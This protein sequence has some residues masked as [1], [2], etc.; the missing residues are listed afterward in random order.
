MKIKVIIKRPDEA[1]GHMT[2]IENSLKNLQ[3]TVDGYIETVTIGTDLVIICN[4]EG[5]LKGLP[6][7]CTICDMDFFGDLIFAGID[8][9][10]FADIPLSMKDFK[11]LMVQPPLPSR[12]ACFSTIRDLLVNEHEKS[13]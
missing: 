6:Y 12:I 1:V 11:A 10:E 4:E 8:G 7:N 3:R 9:D 5:R 13:I 2:W